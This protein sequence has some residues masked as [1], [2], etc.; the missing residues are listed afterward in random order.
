MCTSTMANVQHID[1]CFWGR[2]FLLF[3]TTIAGVMLL[4]RWRYCISVV[5]FCMAP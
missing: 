1:V 4:D 2:D 5:S 3:C